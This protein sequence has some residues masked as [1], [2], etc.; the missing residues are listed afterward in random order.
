MRCVAGMDVGIVEAQVVG[1]TA[2]GR[3]RPT[4]SVIADAHQHA[5]TPVQIARGRVPYFYVA[6]CIVSTVPCRLYKG[7]STI[8][9]LLNPVNEVGEVGQTCTIGFV[10]TIVVPPVGRKVVPR[11][12][13]GDAP[14]C[15]LTSAAPRP[16]QRLRRCTGSRPTLPDALLFCSLPPLALSPPHPFSALL[17]ACGPLLPPALCGGFAAA[18]FAP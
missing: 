3:R 10:V 7:R 2:I 17:R 1:I 9:R 8:S 15:R 18:P 14:T 5:R 16:P 13:G 11:A 12:V 6:L 4:K